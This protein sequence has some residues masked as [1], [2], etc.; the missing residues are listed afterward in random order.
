MLRLPLLFSVGRLAVIVIVAASYV[1]ALPPEWNLP[2]PGAASWGSAVPGSHRCWPIPSTM[3]L[4]YGIGYPEMRLPN[5]LNHE[6][7]KEVEE[8][9]KHWQ[10]LVNTNC[11]PEIRVLLCS[12]YAPVCIEHL[13]EKSIQ[14]CR[15]LCESVKSSCLAIME[16]FGFGWPDMLNCTQFPPENN[17]MCIKRS[18]T[19]TDVAVRSAQCQACVQEP[20][21]E[22]LVSGYCM[23]DI[24]LKARI[25]HVTTG[26][27]GRQFQFKGRLRFFSVPRQLESSSAEEPPR[28][29]RKRQRQRQRRRNVGG[30]RRKSGSRGVSLRLAGGG[31]I[32]NCTLA[33][34]CPLLEAAAAHPKRR[35]LLMGSLAAGGDA[36]DVKFM[37]EWNNR[38]PTFRRALRSIRRD[39]RKRRDSGGSLCSGGASLLGLKTDSGDAARRRQARRNRRKGG[40]GRRRKNR[41]RTDAAKPR[42]PRA[43]R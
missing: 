31:K 36:L 2:Q 37:T 6:S 18:A 22:S 17:L 33:A 7:A 10:A 13:L 40:G 24:V 5:M 9:T 19:Q 28:P 14:P 42:R 25:D 34:D 29:R 4:C 43:E 32:A 8:Q 23:N 39:R 12:I 38:Q 11:H 1:A 20:S 30:R 27:A 41:R 35:Y 26:A 21:Y 3:G 16:K 15:S